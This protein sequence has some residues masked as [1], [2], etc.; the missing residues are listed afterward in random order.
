MRSLSKENTKGFCEVEVIDAV[1]EEEYSYDN[2]LKRISKIKPDIVILETATS[3]F[4]IDIWIARK[5][6]EFAEVCLCGPHATIYAEEILSNN[7][8]L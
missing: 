2:F 7:G 4:D 8:E 3:T 5:I 1:A 6:S